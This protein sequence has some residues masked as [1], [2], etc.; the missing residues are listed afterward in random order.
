MVGRTKRKNDQRKT[1]INWEQV[2]QIINPRRRP[3]IQKYTFNMNIQDFWDV[4][5]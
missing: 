5:Q 3:E 2:I 4:M 1:Q